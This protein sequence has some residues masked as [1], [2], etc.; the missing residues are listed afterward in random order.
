MGSAYFLVQWPLENVHINFHVFIPKLTG[1]SPIFSTKLAAILKNG[2]HLGIS[3]ISDFILV[4]WPLENIH[5]KFHDS[6][7]ILTCTYLPFPLRCRPSWKMAAILKFQVARC[8]FF[9]R[10]PWRM[11]IPNFMLVSP[12]ARF[13]QKSAHFSYTNS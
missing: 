8:I 11:F 12:N 5:A 13:H 9:Q 3:I 7:I 10:T 6:I 2:G 1:T 4:K